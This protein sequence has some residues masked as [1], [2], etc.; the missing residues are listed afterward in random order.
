MIKYIPEKINDSAGRVE[1]P[2]TEIDGV[3]EQGRANYGSLL[4]SSRLDFDSIPDLIELRPAALRPPPLTKT[5]ERERESTLDE[6]LS[7]DDVPK[8]I[9][10]SK[11]IL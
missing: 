2:G 3:R 5:R 9:T 4:D 1:T 6:T 8:H 7:F 10:N 11:Y